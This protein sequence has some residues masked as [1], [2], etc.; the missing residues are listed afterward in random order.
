MKQ[1]PSY[2][3]LAASLMLVPVGLVTGGQIGIFMM[4][5]GIIGFIS[6]LSFYSLKAKK[7]NGKIYH[8]WDLIIGKDSDE[9]LDD[10]SRFAIILYAILLFSTLFYYQVHL[11]IDQIVFFGV[12]GLVLLGRFRKAGRFLWDWIPFALLIFAYDAMRGIADNLGTQVHY[13]E[14]IEAEKLLFFGNLPTIWLQQHFFTPGVVTWYDILAAVF[15]SLHLLL[16]VLFAYLLWI[17]DDKKLF[18]EFRATFILLSYAA[19]VTFLLYPAA[20][21]WLANENGYIPTIYKILFEID[22][23][24]HRVTFYTLYMLVNA[25]PVAAIPSLHVGYPWVMFLFTI[26]YFGKKAF[27][28]ILLPLG[29]GFSSVYLGEHY[30]VDII[31]GIIYAT[32]IYLFVK[33]KLSSYC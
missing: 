15:Y 19:L 20:P 28:V 22:D 29:I 6:Y 2:I 27:P 24:Y 26:R 11:L 8:L 33:K 7:Q 9:R 10:I 17:Q 21:P 12:L 3:H 25:N 14:L 23:V 18:K 13:T 31:I 30:V 32:A 5:A 16:P 1:K 4:L